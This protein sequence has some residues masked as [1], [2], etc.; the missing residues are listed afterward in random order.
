VWAPGTELVAHDWRDDNGCGGGLHLSP[1]PA[2]ASSYRLAA[3]RWLRCTA[4]VEDVRPISGGAPKAK[5]RTVRV[6]AEVDRFGRE[7]VAK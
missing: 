7:L 5:V 3:S 1:T 2:M 4:A 6:E